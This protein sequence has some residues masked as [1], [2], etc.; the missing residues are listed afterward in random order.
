MKKT[1]LTKKDEQLIQ[2]ALVTIQQNFDQTHFNHTVGCALRTE[3]GQVFTGV[4]C[5]GI[6]GACAEYV[7]VGTASAQGQR[8]FDTIVAV[9]PEVPEYVLAPCGNCRQMMI[10][11]CPDI[12]VILKDECGQLIKTTARELLPLANE[13]LN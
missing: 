6:H 12:Q 2:L 11:Y 3:D 10:E 5:D 4:N 9:H 1:A 13:L 7:T 8:A